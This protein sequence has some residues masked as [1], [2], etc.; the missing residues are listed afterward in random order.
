MTSKILMKDYKSTFDSAKPSRKS[1]YSILA[2]IVIIGIGYFLLAPEKTDKQ[3]V[4]DTQIS[5]L[6][7]PG[8]SAPEQPATVSPEPSS[9]TNNPQVAIA[10]PADTQ[11]PAT[12]EPEVSTTTVKTDETERPVMSPTWESRTIKSGDSIA[13]IFREWNLSASLL[14]KIVHSSKLA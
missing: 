11:L 13:N 10:P 2:V 12:V 14:H 4:Q 7:I 9:L 6:Q 8:L 5:A 3:P 1:S